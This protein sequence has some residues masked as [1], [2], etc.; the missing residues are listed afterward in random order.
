M[1]EEIVVQEKS[2][3]KCGLV[4]STSEFYPNKA[5]KSGLRSRCKA[6]ELDG[7]AEKTKA[8]TAANPERVRETKAKYAEKNTERLAIAKREWVESHRELLAENNRRYRNKHRDRV[9]AA[10]RDREKVNPLPRR[11]A[12]DKW[13][14]ENPEVRRMITRNRRAKLKGSGGK[15]P[16][17]FVEGMLESQKW[18][19]VVCRCDLKVSGHELDHII[20]VSKGGAHEAGNVQLLCPTCNK[21]KSAK[22]S[23]EF[24]QQKGYLL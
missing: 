21:Q 22:D 1:T 6:C 3:S 20:P 5:L 15:L 7:A 18:R 17:R 2:C 14:K 8:W 24:M 13:E 10:S 16:T 4:K 23:I 12:R 19:C 11:A 9:N